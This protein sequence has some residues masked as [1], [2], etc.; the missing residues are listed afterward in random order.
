VRRWLAYIWPAVALGGAR[1][2]LFP[3]LAT[4][5]HSGLRLDGRVLTRLLAVTTGLVAQ[6]ANGLS[7]GSQNSSPL[8]GSSPS[9]DFALTHGGVELLLA[10]FMA[11]LALAGL[12][13]LARLTVG[14]EL[15]ESRWWRHRSGHRRF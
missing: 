11:L 15:F 3:L 13:A 6:F 12:V 10:I 5:E 2:I 4:L 8:H 14:E 1:E 7:A 9:F